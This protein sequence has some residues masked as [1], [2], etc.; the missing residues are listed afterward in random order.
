M[1]NLPRLLRPIVRGGVLIAT[2]ALAACSHDMD[3]LQHYA[4]EVKA[5]KTTQIEPIPQ[6]KQY[7]AVPYVADERRDPFVAALPERSGGAGAAA[8]SAIRPDLARNKEPLEEYPLDALRLVGIVT[9]NS[10]IY[11]MVKAPDGVIHRVTNGDHLGQNYGKITKVTEAEVSLSEI[12]PDGFGG[13]I[14]RPAALA[15]NE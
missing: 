7:E 13:F 8:S 4:D 15:A 10:R 6:M 12:I 9:F 2:A 11:A 3:D 1:R 5:R 14:E